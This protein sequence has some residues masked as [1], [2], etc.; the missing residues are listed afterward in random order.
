MW[1]ENILLYKMDAYI[2]RELKWQKPK[3]QVKNHVSQVNIS[4]AVQKA[5]K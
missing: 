5:V 4:N 3:S 2:L 1:A